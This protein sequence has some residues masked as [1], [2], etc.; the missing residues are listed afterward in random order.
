MRFFKKSIIY[1]ED[2]KPYLVR[3][4]LFSCRWFALKL[5]HILLSDQSCQH[6]H[7]WSFLTFLIWGGYV[8]HTP[9]KSK[10][11]SRFSLLYRHA[12][13]VHRLEIYQP[14]WS[15]VITFKKFREWGFIT[16]KGW[17]KWYQYRYSNDC[18]S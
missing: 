17:I 15:I 11:Y 5:H 2:R 6:D 8:E 1:R 7:P 9:T 16:P 12:T 14:V 3:Y 4:S 18:Q 10:V 13:Y